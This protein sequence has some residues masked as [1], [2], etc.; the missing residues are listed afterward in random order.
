MYYTYCNMIKVVLVSLLVAFGKDKAKDKPAAIKAGDEVVVKT[1]CTVVKEKPDYAAKKLLDLK[2]GHV[3]KVLEIKGNWS[4][5]EYEAGK[6]GYINNSSYIIRELYI[7]SETAATSGDVRRIQESAAAKGFSKDIEQEFRKDKN[8]NEQYKL[9]DEL[10]IKRPA[11][12][13][14]GPDNTV[15]MEEIAKAVQKFREEGQLK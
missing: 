9:L 15:S 3:V 11:F 14:L 5:V 6:S 4:R 12:K 2:E 10:I 7:P 1:K 13:R 8:L